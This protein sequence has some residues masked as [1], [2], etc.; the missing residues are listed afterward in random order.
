MNYGLCP[1]SYKIL[2]KTEYVDRHMDRYIQRLHLI[3]DFLIEKGNAIHHNSMY[4][5]IRTLVGKNNTYI[6]KQT[7]GRIQRLEL[8]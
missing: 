5:K 8:I 7:D 3:Y 1:F 2:K 6:D 4:T